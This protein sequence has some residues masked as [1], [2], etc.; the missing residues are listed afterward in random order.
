MWNGVATRLARLREF[1]KQFQVFGAQEHR[2]Q[3]YPRL[4]EEN[5]TELERWVVGAR[6]PE[7]LRAF[8]RDV[9]NGVAGPHYGLLEAQS[10]RGYRPREPYAEA[11]TR[12][13]SEVEREQLTGLI[14]II[15]EGCGHELCLVANGPQSGEVVRVSADDH[16][17]ETH[18]TFLETYEEWVDREIGKFETVQ[19]LM[20]SGASLDEIHREVRE[21]FDTLDAEDIVASIANVEKPVE[22]FGTQHHKIYHGATQTPWYAKVLRDWQNTNAG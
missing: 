21:K 10:V 5:L 8:Y 3:L 14:S 13:S 2:Y 9:G 18:R 16:V 22:L 17:Y 7:E 4:A 11:A 12:G 20:S 15:N 6:F 19:Q 1:D